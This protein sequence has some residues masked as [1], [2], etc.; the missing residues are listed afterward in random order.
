MDRRTLIA[1]AVSAALLAG[2]AFAEK[3][4]TKLYNGKDL[5]GWHVK[6]GKNESWKANGDMISCVAPGGGWLTSD[7][8]YGDFELH[9]DY[10]IPPGGNSGVGIRYPAQG[11]PA[12]V[13]MEIQI[14]D[15][16]A[17][18]YKNLV[19]AQY[20]GGIYYQVAPRTKAAKKPGEWNHYVIRCQGPRVQVWL[21]GVQ[22]QDA[23]M[24]EHTKG[25]GGHMALSERPRRGFVGLQSHG[26]QV[27]FR[28]IEI[29]EL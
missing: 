5:T 26:N 19:P 14:L 16:D 1:G 29:K 24:D 12:H 6:D 8:E 21:N 10:R 17:P 23:N 27:D 15:D 28:N 11:D 9:V 7:K 4:F 3:G 18:E 20:T 13:G 22:I 2:A 25:E